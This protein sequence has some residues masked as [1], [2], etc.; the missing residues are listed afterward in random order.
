MVWNP[1]GR[2]VFSIPTTY[3]YGLPRQNVITWRGLSFFKS[4]LFLP[5]HR[6]DKPHRILFLFCLYYS[7]LSDWYRGFDLYTS[8]SLQ[9]FFYMTSAWVYVAPPA[10]KYTKHVCVVAVTIQGYLRPRMITL[11]TSIL[12]TLSLRS[13]SPYHFD[14]YHLITSTLI[15]LSLRS[16]SPYHLIT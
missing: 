3:R 9:E 4:S 12:F 7:Q 11:I 6:Y 16:L 13:L 5:P 8:D 10:E 2:Q 15:T 14:P 1:Q